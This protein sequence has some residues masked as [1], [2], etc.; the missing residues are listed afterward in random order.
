M[1]GVLWSKVYKLWI[2]TCCLNALGVQ[3]V[4]QSPLQSVEGLCLHVGSS[5]HCSCTHNAVYWVLKLERGQ[6][7][8]WALWAVR[9]AQVNSKMDPL[10]FWVLT[11]SHICKIRW[12]C[13][14]SKPWGVSHWPQIHSGALEI[15][16]HW[17]KHDL[18]TWSLSAGARWVI[19][20]PSC[21][22]DWHCAFV[23]PLPTALP[24]PTAW[25]SLSKCTKRYY[26][27]PI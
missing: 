5:S 25:N 12:Q 2:W 1:F 14:D 23:L 8:L 9:Q 15:F 3:N 11:P 26:K 22:R 19:W 10:G 18:A 27:A 7:A 17:P 24:I 20:L 4:M 21:K 13:Q 16:L 6:N